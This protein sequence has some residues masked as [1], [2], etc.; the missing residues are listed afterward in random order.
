MNMLVTGV[1]IFTVA[2]LVP[3][4]AAGVRQR[5]VAGMGENAWKGVFLLLMIA[6]LVLMVAGWRSTA[7]VELYVAPAWG[8]GVASICMLAM[9]IL[10]FAPYMPNNLSRLV[11]HP[12]LAGMALFGVGHLA[13]VGN[14]RSVVLFG[15]FALWSVV[16]IVLLNRRDGPWDRPAATARLNDLKLLLAG[17]GFFL[18]F[19]F[20]HGPLFGAPL[21]S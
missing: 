17:L 21:L 18:I 2:H 20:L 11:R 7:E 3:A 14:V 4:G 5:L 16:E 19:L 6:S 8:A 10:F 13:A 1:L 15:G 12:Q 9:A